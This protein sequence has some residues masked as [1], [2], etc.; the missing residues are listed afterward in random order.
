MFSVYHF[1]GETGLQSSLNSRNGRIKWFEFIIQSLNYVLFSSPFL[2]ISWMDA[3]LFWLLADIW[4]K[5]NTV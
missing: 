4:S 3:I 1:V 2:M 5:S